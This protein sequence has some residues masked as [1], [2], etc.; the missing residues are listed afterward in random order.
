MTS[1]WKK[2]T[3]KSFDFFP[4]ICIRKK[5]RRYIVKSEDFKI[6]DNQQVRFLRE[7]I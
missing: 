6:N 7:A 5:I 4:D 2:I 3:I 1:L